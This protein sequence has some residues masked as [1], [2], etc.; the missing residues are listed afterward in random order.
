MVHV[1]KDTR[2]WDYSV[3]WSPW[4]FTSTHFSIN[5]TP[6]FQAIRKL[7][8]H[9]VASDSSEV[10]GHSACS[11]VCSA[12]V[13]HSLFYRI[14]DET[15]ITKIPPSAVFL[16]VKW[17]H[18]LDCVVI[19]QCSPRVDAMSSHIVDRQHNRYPFCVVWTPLPV[20]RWVEPNGRSILT[21]YVPSALDSLR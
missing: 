7:I 2:Q 20:L 1:W 9:E 19:A 11:S 16:D 17:C 21:K 18:C 4:V 3:S 13:H 15:F 12:H 14:W 8:V 10:T 6:S 5:S